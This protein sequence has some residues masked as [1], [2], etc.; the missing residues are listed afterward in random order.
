MRFLESEVGNLLYLSMRISSFFTYLS[1]SGSRF[2]SSRRKSTGH[3]LVVLVI[4]R[5]ASFWTL[6]SF[7]RLVLDNQ[8]DQLL[9]AY[10]RQLRMNWM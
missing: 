9:D 3:V 6:S 2:A 8:G 7:W 5:R 1:L 4:E 10:S